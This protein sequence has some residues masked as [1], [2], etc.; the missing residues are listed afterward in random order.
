MNDY[1]RSGLAKGSVLRYSE[2]DDCPKNDK[3]DVAMPAENNERFEKSIASLVEITDALLRGEFRENLPDVDAEGLLSLLA[4]KINAMLVN[5]K[6]VQAPLA[7]AGEQAPFVV[8]H[9]RDVVELMEQASSAVL[10]KSD[11]VIMHAEELERLLLAGKDGNATA[12]TLVVELKAAMYDII[13]SQSY[14]DVARQK[15]E[16]I[17][18][19][20]V[21]IRNWLIEVLVILNIKKDSSAE[22]VEKKK[23][24][25][26]EVHAAGA[27]PSLKQDLVDD[28]LAEFGF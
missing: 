23:E 28:L 20:L 21:Q 22:N 2:K 10:D 15:M 9:A 27:A 16:K 26:R 5:M 4:T 12:R 19:D 14:Q 17:I 24:I 3:T 8:S 7:S 6:T 18:V 11:R 13:A 1:G 25:L